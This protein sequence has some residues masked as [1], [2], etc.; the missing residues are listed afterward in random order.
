MVAAAQK[1]GRLLSVIAQ[2]RF[3]PEMMGL[4]AVLR[5]GL[6]GR[7]LSAQVDSFW[8]RG[9]TY[10]DLAWRGTWEQEGGG[11][12]LNHAVH[13]F[14]LLNWMMGTLPDTVEAMMANVD[15][16]NSEVEDLS[17]AVLRYP[18]GALGQITSSVVHHGQDQQLVFQGERARVSAPWRVFASVG[19]ENGFPDRAEDVERELEAFYGA[20]PPLKHPRHLGQIEDVL[21]AL[22]TGRPPFIGGE[23]GRRTVELIAAVYGAAASAAPVKLPLKPEDPWYRRESFMARMPRFHKKSKS[24][25]RFGKND[26]TT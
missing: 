3:R 5:E 12:T 26:I 10:Y 15:H 14:D 6:A 8:W 21:T 13:H 9:P 24:V 1:S 7:I 18:D 19:R 20:L 17:V 16:P 25:E 2:N 23:D 22:E 11:P 4:H